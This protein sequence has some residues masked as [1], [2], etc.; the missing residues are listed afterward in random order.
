MA[1]KEGFLAGMMNIKPVGTSKTSEG[2]IC[3]FPL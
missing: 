3:D 2:E 1:G